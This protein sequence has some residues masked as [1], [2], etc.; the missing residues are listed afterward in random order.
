MKAKV[1]SIS[2]RHIFNEIPVGGLEIFHQPTDFIDIDFSIKMKVRDFI[3]HSD[4]FRMGKDVDVF[5]VVKNKRK[6]Y[7]NN[8]SNSKV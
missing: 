1:N 6:K 2:I 8:K 5:V 7:E 3:L 4:V